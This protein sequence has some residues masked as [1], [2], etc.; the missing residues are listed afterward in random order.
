MKKGICI[1]SE[2]WCVNISEEAEP[3]NHSATI[4]WRNE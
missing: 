1:G 2:P 4:N 3:I